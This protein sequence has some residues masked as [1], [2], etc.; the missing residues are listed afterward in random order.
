MQ[1]RRGAAPSVAAALAAA[2]VAASLLAVVLVSRS[3]DWGSGGVRDLPVDALIGVTFPLCALLVLAGTTPVRTMAVLLLASG[4]AASAAA[5]TTAVA[6]IASTPSSGVLVAV[7]LQSFLWVP[8]FLAVVTLVPLLYPD[9]RLPT[10]RW[11]PVLVMALLGIAAMT[12]GSALHPTP[13]VGRATFDK[14]VTSDLSVPFFVAGAALST[15]SMV[16]ALASL[17]VRWRRESGLRRRQV[18][19]LLVA[20]GLLAVDV[21][22]TAY[23]P[24]PASTAVQAVA[25][26]LLP[27][28][29]TVAVTRHR[30]YEL[31]T[32][33]RHTVTGVGLAGSLAGLYL[34][35]FAL[36]RALLP[37]GG[38]TASVVAAG[39]TGLALQPLARRL[40]QAVDRWFYGDREQ[41][42][43]VLARLGERLREAGTPDEVTGAV[44]ATLAEHLRLDVVAEVVVGPETQDPV[45]EVVLLRHRGE[46]VGRLVVTPRPGEHRLDPRDREVLEGAA[47]LAAPA[48]AAVRLAAGLQRSREL[49]VAAREEERRRLRRDLHDGVGAALAGAR[50]QLESAQ[51]RVSDP[52]A[53][54]MVDAAVAAVGEAVD[55]V[56]HATDD[57]R[58][59]AL[60]ELGLVGCLRLLAERMSTPALE[61]RAD[62]DPLPVLGAAVEVAC[63]RICAEAL[64]N[65]CRHAR[66]ST[67]ALR[68]G[69]DGR[70]LRVVVTDDGTGLPSTTRSGALGLE[71]MRLRAEEVG[72]ML[73]LE[74]GPHGTNV[75]AVLP[76]MEDQ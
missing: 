61:V 21:V 45:D 26:A 73:S 66:A 19:V 41:P 68:V 7:Q 37:A 25:V 44:A 60:D 5:L 35:L 13:F 58:P 27:V 71:S 22:V 30:L 53:R 31:D 24:W 23:L 59:P 10:A 28:A 64:T 4:A 39:L 75:A 74:S 12:L 62:V 38:A 65:A 72:G 51:E 2:A 16:L 70:A 52:R 8:A 50:L 36:L 20:V 9:G 6:A 11:R 69:V 63:Y 56:R 32:A 1:P 55:G 14:P 47:V 49:L 18:S 57:L 48:V 3:G 17:V 42:Q 34:T 46:V 76:I 15:V 67:V 43:V 40:A 33:L 54:R 29:I